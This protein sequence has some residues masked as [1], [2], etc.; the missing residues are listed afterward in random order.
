[1][2]ET[3]DVDASVEDWLGEIE[4]AVGTIIPKSHE[5]SYRPTLEERQALYWFIA[6]MFTRVP[7][8][9]RVGEEIVGP[10]LNELLL[11]A[12]QDASKFRELCDSY[13]HSSGNV[14]FDIELLRQ[15]VLRGDY[16]S[17]PP[18]MRLAS[19]VETSR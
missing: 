9:F 10:R 6:V 16:V 13:S 7:E 2:T 15:E 4:T 8:A 11:A 12:A 1:M 18:W 14:P 17:E 3:G 19:L 5:T